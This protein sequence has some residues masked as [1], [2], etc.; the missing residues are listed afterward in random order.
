MRM[1][2]WDMTKPNRDGDLD[3]TIIIHE[4]GHGISTRLT[5]GPDNSNCLSSGEAAGKTHTLLKY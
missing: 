5:G 3:A 1:Y 4:Y 2:V